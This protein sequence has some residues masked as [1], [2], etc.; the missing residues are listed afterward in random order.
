MHN[1]VRAETQNDG[2]AY[3]VLSRSSSARNNRMQRFRM[4]AYKDFLEGASANDMHN[5]EC[6]FMMFLDRRQSPFPA[7]MKTR[8]GSDAGFLN[9]VFER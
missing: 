7:S 3:H 5:V 2:I 6:A 4:H 9:M 1:L 8:V